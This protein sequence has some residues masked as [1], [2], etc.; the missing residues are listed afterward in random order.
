MIYRCQSSDTA[1]PDLHMQKH[2]AAGREEGAEASTAAA[3][4][5]HDQ[6]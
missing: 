1:S 6:E 2:E 5:V 3:V 4:R